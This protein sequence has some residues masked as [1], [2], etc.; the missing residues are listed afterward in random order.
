MFL[1]LGFYMIQ[2][3]YSGI[4]L[5]INIEMNLVAGIFISTI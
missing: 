4:Q 5:M 2:S 1:V 3:K